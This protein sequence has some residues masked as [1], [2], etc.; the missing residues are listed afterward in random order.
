MFR[1]T[2]LPLDVDIFIDVVDKGQSF[3]NC[4]GQMDN[5]CELVI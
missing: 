1:S 5:L 2:F 3:L 4:S